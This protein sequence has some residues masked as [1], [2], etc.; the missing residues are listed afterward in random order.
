M[1]QRRVIQALA[2]VGAVALSVGTVVRG[3]TNAA[4]F[5][6]EVPW[7]GNGVWLKVDTHT[8]T[9]FSDGSRT[10]DEIPSRGAIYG[11]DA[12]AITDHSDLNLKGATPE[13]FDAIEKGRARRPNMIVFAGIEWNVPP[14]NGQ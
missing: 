7:S 9:R 1:Q 13:Y 8:H 3:Q 5:V 11:W 12:I 10:V 2:I 4:R 14:D 6:R